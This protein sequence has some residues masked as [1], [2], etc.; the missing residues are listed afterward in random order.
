M[1]QAPCTA[2]IDL[3]E[4]EKLSELRA[5]TDRQ[6]LDFIHSRLDVANQAFNEAQNLLLALD[7]DQRRGLERKLNDIERAVTG[8][9]LLRA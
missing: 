6:I 4:T 9:S 3:P 8:R 2:T 5:K 7:E 1:S